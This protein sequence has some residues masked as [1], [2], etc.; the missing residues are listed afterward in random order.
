MKLERIITYQIVIQGF[1]LCSEEA[2][3]SAPL[4]AGLNYGGL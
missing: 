2:G 1:S 4:A 3:L